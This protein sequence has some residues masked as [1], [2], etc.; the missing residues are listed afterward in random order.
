MFPTVTPPSQVS[1][2]NVFTYTSSTL[3]SS[4]IW[5]CLAYGAGLFVAVIRATNSYATSPDGINWTSRTLPTTANWKC[6]IF[7]GTKFVLGAYSTTTMLTSTDGLTWSST[8]NNADNYFEYMAYGNGTYIV[9]MYNQSDCYT[10]TTLGTWTVRTLPLTANWNQVIFG[11]GIF[12]LTADTNIIAMSI[13]NGVTWKTVTLP[14]TSYPMGGF[15]TF[16]NGLFILL[17]ATNTIAISQ[18]AITWN[19]ITLPASA[20]WQTATYGNGMY[21]IF[22]SNYGYAATSFD[23][24]H[25]TLRPIKNSTWNVS[26]YGANNF[27]S[28]SY[29]NNTSIAA[30]LTNG[31]NF[32]WNKTTNTDILYPTQSNMMIQL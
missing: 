6:L 31:L 11:N 28:V 10:A 15:G 1:W 29:S 4:N 23:G 2:K 27:V 25:W 14:I 3:P 12:I 20:T 8:L 24:I 30:N 22:P 7:D 13:D 19:I 9:S 16:A 26:A 18:N 21:V 17:G 32:K 5:Q